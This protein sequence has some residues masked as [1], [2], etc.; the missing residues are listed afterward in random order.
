M[1]ILGL[2]KMVVVA[3]SLSGDKRAASKSGLTTN[4]EPTLLGVKA[5]SRTG[6]LL[7][8]RPRLNSQADAFP[9][10]AAQGLGKARATA[11]TE[12]MAPVTVTVLPFGDAVRVGRSAKGGG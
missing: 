2:I 9:A 10:P 11:R 7:V 12:S 4:V 6:K 1:V 5:A 3:R 8:L